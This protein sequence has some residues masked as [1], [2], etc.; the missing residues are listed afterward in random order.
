VLPKISTKAVM[1]G[2]WLYYLNKELKNTGKF[3]VSV[4]FPTNAFCFHIFFAN[5]KNKFIF[6]KAI[7]S[8]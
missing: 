1:C 7:F 8:K 2:E 3:P 5:R 4:F 6:H